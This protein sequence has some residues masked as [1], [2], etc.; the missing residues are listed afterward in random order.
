[1]EPPSAVGGPY[2]VQ[3]D[4]HYVREG[5]IHRQR[6]NFEKH[7]MH[8]EQSHPGAVNATILSS[9]AKVSAGNRSPNDVASDK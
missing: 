3:S 4:T 8:R 6:S 5:A 1:M 2:R 7:K 9:Q